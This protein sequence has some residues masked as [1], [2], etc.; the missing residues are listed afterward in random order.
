[1]TQITNFSLH[2]LVSS[3]HLIGAQHFVPES[4]PILSYHHQLWKLY[5]GGGGGGRRDGVYTY[6]YD[7]VYKIHKEQVEV[8]TTQVV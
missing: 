6:M 1:M 3:L 2:G 8:Y 4:V 7:V 5:W